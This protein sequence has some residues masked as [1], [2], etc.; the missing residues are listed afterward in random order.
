[1][2]HS[3]N[4]GGEDS[5]LRKAEAVRRHREKARQE[6]EEV[7]GRSEFLRRENPRLK[8]AI[9]G[10]R[11]EV[12]HMEEAVRGWQGGGGQAGGQGVQGGSRRELGGFQGDNRRE[13]GGFQG[14]SRRQAWGSQE[15]SWRKT[16]GNLEQ[17][18]G[19]LG[20]CLGPTEGGWQDMGWQPDSY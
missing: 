2:Y 1:M 12:E 14:G 16:Q 20:G 13:S 7:Q 6:R 10:V 5:L 8:L 9:Q 17:T 3:P 15:D 18:A 11:Q 19:V 4:Q